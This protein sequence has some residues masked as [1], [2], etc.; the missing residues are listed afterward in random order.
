MRH[1]MGVKTWICLALGVINGICVSV[2]DF[3]SRRWAGG[4]ALEPAA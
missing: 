4:T 1:D 3:G 2:G